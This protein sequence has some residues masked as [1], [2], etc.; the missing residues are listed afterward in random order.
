MGLTRR[1]S[2]SFLDKALDGLDD[3]RDPLNLKHDIP[4][5]KSKSLDVAKFSKP[6]DE[7]Q[8]NDQDVIDQ[9][10]RYGLEAKNRTST[11]L[12][13]TMKFNA[14][15]GVIIVINALLM[16]FQTDT[17]HEWVTLTFDGG[18]TDDFCKIFTNRLPYSDRM[19]WFVIDNIFTT[20]FLFELIARIVTDG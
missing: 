14:F 17:C 8:L 1:Q 7:K 2:H 15:M 11:P 13:H 19:V 16:Y 3:P 9:F 5:F 12:V 6:D 10:A 20:I 4:R 18:V